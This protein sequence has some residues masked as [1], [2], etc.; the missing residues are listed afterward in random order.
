MRLA[1]SHKI[2]NKNIQERSTYVH[3]WF[4]LIKIVLAWLLSIY[5]VVSIS[6]AMKVAYYIGCARNKGLWTP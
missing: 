5:K 3:P 6:V 1:N 4:L 2:L